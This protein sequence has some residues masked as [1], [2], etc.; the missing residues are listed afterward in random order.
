MGATGHPRLSEAM[1]LGDGAEIRIRPLTPGDRSGVA[2]LFPRLSPRSRYRR[3]LTP[4]R[5]LT[6]RELVFFTDVDH[7]RH[8]ALAAIDPRDNSVVGVARYVQY[9]DRPRVASIA[10]E[11]ADD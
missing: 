1:L 6:D 3:F 5:E 4:K 9:L 10:F 8:G 11:V 2:A 7:V